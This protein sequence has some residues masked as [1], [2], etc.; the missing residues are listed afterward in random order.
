MISRRTC[1][2]LKEDG[3]P[4]LL[5]CDSRYS[6][7]CC[8]RSEACGRRSQT[9]CWRSQ[10]CHWRSQTCHWRS[11]TYR[12]CTQTCHQRTQTCRRHSHVLPGAP[13]V[14]SGALRCFQ[15]YHNHFHGTPVPVIR[16]LSYS[17][18][19]SECPPMVWYSPDIDPSKFTLH[20]LSDTSGGSQRLKYIL[21]MVPHFIV[22]FLC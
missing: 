9:P 15:T 8:R 10:T 11:Q 22:Y 18:G 17:K 20:I 19:R 5:N 16:A 3:F 14:L 7:T 1:S 12:W 21:L 6:Q 4:R 13:K 2:V